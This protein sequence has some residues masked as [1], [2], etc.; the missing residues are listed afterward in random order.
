[1]LDRVRSL[2]DAYDDS[3]TECDGMTRICHTV[4]SRENIPHFCM[5]GV[6]R[7]G[8]KRLP[9]HFWIDLL[10]D[11][12]GYRIDYRA[13]LWFGMSPDVPHGVFRPEHFPK[14]NYEGKAVDLP[15]LSDGV[16]RVLTMPS[17]YV[18]SSQTTAINAYALP[19][20]QRSIQY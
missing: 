7:H 12:E 19:F 17:Q 13:R 6:S 20:V 5:V 16:F 2:L 1:M 3:F 10:E 9:I 11:M 18:S 4:L 15:L 14:V 8:A